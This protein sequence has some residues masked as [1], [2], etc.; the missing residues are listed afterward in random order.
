MPLQSGHVFASHIGH[1]GK[2]TLA[3][4]MSCYYANKHPDCSVLVMDLSEE[5][6]LTK[7]FLGG[8][9]A[10]G[11][12]VDDL[13]GGVF[14]LLGAAEKRS[15]GLTSWLWGSA[16]NVTDHAIRVVEH[17]PA[18]PQN[19]YLISSGAW[20]RNEPPMEDEI[21]RSVS[22]RI[23][24][25]LDKSPATWKLFCDTD[26]DRRPSPYTMLAYSL[27][28]QAIVPL[29]LN[30]GDLDRTETMLGVMH[31]LRCRGEIQT[32][33]LLVVWNFVKCLKDEPCA[34][35]DMMLP[36]TPT[37][38]CMDILDSCNKRLYKNAQ[39]LEGL[40]VHAGSSETDFI[41]N[42]TTTLRQLADN[43]LKPSE[44][45]GLPFVEMVNRLTASGKKSM[46]FQTGDVSY[47]T[48]GDTIETV[49]DSLK[50]LEDK[51]EAMS[52]G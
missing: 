51:F 21:R 41:K 19:L 4:Q 15:S 46:K 52:I 11:Q 34:Y 9:D 20:P 33:V 5:G 17:N 22:S 37:K 3:F 2:T 32:Q 38:V 25:S 40:F 47:D 16:F 12:K 6:D 44:E 35:H 24:E 26:G 23:S 48:K 1:T 29:H 31:D 49:F 8:V 28:S 13:F 43:V 18:I 39:E 50:V 7:R 45:L 14:R 10:A 27:C 30:K 42:S 36:F